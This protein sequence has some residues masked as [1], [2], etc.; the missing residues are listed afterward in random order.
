MLCVYL[1]VNKLPGTWYINVYVTICI[2]FSALKSDGK[3]KKLSKPVSQPAPKPVEPVVEPK[4]NLLINDGNFM[5]R[6]KQM[7]GLKSGQAQG[8]CRI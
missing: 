2:Y 4:P 3:G 7:Q 1:P 8:L 5:E 6:F